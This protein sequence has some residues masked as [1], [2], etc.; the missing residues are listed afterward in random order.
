MP[1]EWR[2][3]T[4]I[5]FFKTGGDNQNCANYRDIKLMSNMIGL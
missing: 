1:N 3:S 2:K 5:P 4:M